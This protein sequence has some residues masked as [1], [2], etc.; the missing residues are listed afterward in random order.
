VKEKEHGG[1]V[2]HRGTEAQ[3]TQRGGADNHHCGRSVP[4]YFSSPRAALIPKLRLT[5][6]GTGRFV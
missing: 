5:K 2:Y 3:R 1:F 6:S 4:H